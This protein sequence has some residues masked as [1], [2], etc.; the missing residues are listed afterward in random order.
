MFLTRRETS[1]AIMDI[2]HEPWNGYP[3]SNP[4]LTGTETQDGTAAGLLPVSDFSK[5]RVE[6]PE[7]RET[8]RASR[9]VTTQV[10]DSGTW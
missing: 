10:W 1:S 9:E 7:A 6:W 3:L 5:G 4:C 8:C 2:E